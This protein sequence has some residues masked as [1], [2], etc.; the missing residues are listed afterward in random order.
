MKELTKDW[1]AFLTAQ[2]E[3]EAERVVTADG[4]F[5]QY[6]NLLSVEQRGA[7]EKIVEQKVDISDWTDLRGHKHKK[8]HGKMYLHFVSPADRLI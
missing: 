8:K 4:I 3:A 2:T 7:W 1:D 6:A 5:T